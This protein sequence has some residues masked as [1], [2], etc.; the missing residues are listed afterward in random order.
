[1]LITDCCWS[2]HEDSIYTIWPGFKMTFS[3]N[4][5][6]QSSLE[7][8]VRVG[9]CNQNGPEFYWGIKGNELC[10]LC[11]PSVYLIS[12]WGFCFGSARTEREVNYITKW[13][14]EM[15]FSPAWRL[16]CVCSA[17]VCEGCCGYDW[18]E[19]DAPSPVDSAGSFRPTALWCTGA[20]E[21]AV[22]VLRQRAIEFRA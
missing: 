22:A 16:G 12:M 18:A 2:Q 6:S 21:W 7:H 17:W 20:V 9:V 14:D 10:V 1:M 19:L 5:I 3:K 15:P 11:T 8:D 4:Q 13:R